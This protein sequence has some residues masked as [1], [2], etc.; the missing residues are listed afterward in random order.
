MQLKLPSER[1][2]LIGMCMT[3]PFRRHFCYLS[4]SL[5]VSSWQIEVSS[6]ISQWLYFIISNG[7]FFKH[8]VYLILAISIVKSFMEIFNPLNKS[9]T[10]HQLL[11]FFFHSGTTQ[12][13]LF[14]WQLNNIRKLK[15]GK[16]KNWSKPQLTLHTDPSFCPYRHPLQKAIKL[17]HTNNHSWA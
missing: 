8:R 3:S 4:K 10:T 9:Q 13:A 11:I 17:N 6:D 2:I 16:C 14:S 7:A 1:H 5:E 15:C 12:F